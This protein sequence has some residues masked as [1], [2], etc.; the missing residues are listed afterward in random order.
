LLFYFQFRSKWKLAYLLLAGASGALSATVKWT[1]LTFLAIICV[2]EAIRCLRE[3]PLRGTSFGRATGALVLLPMAIYFSIVALHLALLYKSG[4][5]DAF[6]TPR[7]QKT[8]QGSKF[9]QDASLGPMDLLE[10]VEQLNSEMYKA[11]ATL[12]TGHPYGSKWY[13]W[14]I[15]VRPIFYWVKKINGSE[16]E[17]IYFL[18]NPI[19]WW[20]STAAMAYITITLLLTAAIKMPGKWNQIPS[21]AMLLTAAYFFNLLPFIGITRVMFLYHYMT[22]LVFAYLALAYLIDQ[23]ASPA[24]FIN[25]VVPASRRGARDNPAPAPAMNRKL[26][27]GILLTGS[28]ASFLFFSPLTYGWALTDAAYNL[29]VWLPSWR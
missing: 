18:G 14:P 3:N 29:R 4:P 24:T 1:G 21:S 28:I 8:L 26:I 6:M 20:C 15:L 7:F 10:K 13:S 11:N 22:A 17:R 27:Y 5:G 9:A 19:S 2:L 25:E 12:T 16:Q 23:L